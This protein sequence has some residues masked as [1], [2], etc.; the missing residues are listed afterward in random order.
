TFSL[1]PSSSNLA[2]GI[3]IADPLTSVPAQSSTRNLDGLDRRLMNAQYK[4]GSILTTHG[5][6]VDSTGAASSTGGRNGMRWYEITGLPDV[7]G[8]F[9]PSIRQSGT[10][11]DPSATNP[12]SY[13]AGSIAASGQGHVALGSSFAGS[14][15]FVGA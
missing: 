2:I 10:L 9:S 1:T 11:F 6:Q 8:A 7:S 14:S 12:L 3:S 15:S 4:N 5:I 13:W